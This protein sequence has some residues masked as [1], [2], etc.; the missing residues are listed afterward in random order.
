MVSQPGMGTTIQIAV[1]GIESVIAADIFV[2]GILTYGHILF[3][4]L[5]CICLLGG[6]L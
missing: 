1:S 3:G 5:I 2:V 6:C 4:T